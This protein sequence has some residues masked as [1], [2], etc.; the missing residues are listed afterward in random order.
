MTYL[1]GIDLG[2]T[3]CSVILGGTKRLGSGFQTSKSLDDFFITEKIAFP[4]PTNN[5]AE[6]IRLISGA[7]KQLLDRH[8][9]KIEQILAA[10]I[11][12]GGPLDSQKGIILS[13]PNLPGWDEIQITDILEKEIGIRPVLQNDANACAI[14]ELKW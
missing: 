9:F 8:D 6:T 7:V 5:P 2:G 11:S 4:M 1:I 14:A 3:K 13:P 12:C 10:G